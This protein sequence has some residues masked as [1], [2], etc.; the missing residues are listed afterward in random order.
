MSSEKTGSHIKRPEGGNANVFVSLTCLLALLVFAGCGSGTSSM[1]TGGGGGGDR[2][3]AASV[4][5]T[6]PVGTA[7][8]GIAVDS[9]GNKIYV[10]DFGVAPTQ[11]D[12]QACS[13]TGADIMVIDGATRSPV[14]A[15]FPLSLPNLNPTFLAF[16]PVTHTVNVAAFEYGLGSNGTG[17]R[18]DFDDVLSIDPSN[19]SAAGSIYQA[20]VLRTATLGAI[21][22]DQNSGDIYLGGGTSEGGVSFSFITV[23]DD[24]GAM[25]AEIGLGSLPLGIVLDTN[26][27]TSTIYAGTSG[28]FGFNRPS[29]SVIDQTTNTVTATIT[30]PN[31]GGPISVAFNPS[32]NTIYAANEQSNNVSVIDAATTTVTATIPVGNSPTG[33]GV[34][35]QTNFIY[36][37][38]SGFQH[39]N[40]PGSVTVIDG[41]TNVTTT[42][43]DPNAIGPES[44]AVNPATNKVYV[45]NRSNN[46]TVIDGAH[47]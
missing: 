28:I 37:A 32:T 35:P 41:K 13:P 42:L 7:P 30:D 4:S 40:D 12:S 24:T 2:P 34:N 5:A 8:F 21:A 15:G 20:A 27:G 22:V 17:C 19:A 14:G 25:K 23:L 38:N 16:N 46:V 6:I 44:V 29:V 47:E 9:V 3:V 11:S 45:T 39:A 31:A 43:T 18:N 33:I 1:N 36:V 26:P 10:A